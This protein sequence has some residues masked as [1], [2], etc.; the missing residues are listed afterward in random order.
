MG[1]FI[2]IA[3]LNGSFPHKFIE[4]ALLNGSFPHKFTT[5]LQNTFFKEHLWVFDFP[6]KVVKEKKNNLKIIIFKNHKQNINTRYV[7][8]N[9]SVHV[10]V[11]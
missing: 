8:L 4:I 10:S 1:N 2:E 5:Y 7:N 6:E 11:S 9:V 3:L